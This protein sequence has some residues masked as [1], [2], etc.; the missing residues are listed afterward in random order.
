MADD[1]TPAEDNAIVTLLLLIARRAPQ[2]WFYQVHARETGSN[3][4]ALAEVAEWLYLEG[5]VQKAPGSR[6]TGPGLTVTPFGEQVAADPGLLDR[7]RKGEPL[8]DRDVGATVRQGLLRDSY[9]T[10]TRV[11]IGLNVLAFA[12]GAYRASQLNIFNAYIGGFPSNQREA[13]RY[14]ALLRDLGASFPALVLAGEWW[15][16]ITS[17]FLHGGALHILMNMFALNSLGRFVEQTWGWWRLVLIYAV[18][19]WAGSCLA[20]SQATA[21][22]TVGA[23]G[24][25]CGLMGAEGVWVALYG[26]YLPRGFTRRLRSQFLVNVVFLVFISLMPGISWQGHLGGA[27]GGAAAALLLHVHRFGPSLLRWP[28]LAAL[29]LVVWGCYSWMMTKA[30]ATKEG[31]AAIQEHFDETVGKQARAAARE[32]MRVCGEQVQPLMERNARR[33]DPKEVEAALDALAA[34]RAEARRLLEA[35]P[36]GGGQQAREVTAQ[37]LGE[38]VTLCDAATEYLKK[39]A[40]ARRSDENELRARFGRLDDLEF[41]HRKLFEGAAKER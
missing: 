5:L 22:P 12:Y 25:I 11:L 21:A 10:A 36:R 1:P 40:D 4:R 14:L 15:R 16:L 17:T 39:G 20:A 29:P 7:L 34:A 26:R 3:P 6:E 24:A 35:L 27:V 2:P 28:A 31:R 8:R 32:V 30:S 13:V 37:L 9:P 38:S 41:E 18:G 19:A 33:R 23:S